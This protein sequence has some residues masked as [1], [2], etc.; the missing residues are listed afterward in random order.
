[1]IDFKRQLESLIMPLTVELFGDHGVAID[2]QETRK[3]FNADFTLV[4]FPFLKF[5]KASPEKTAEIV[6]SKISTELSEI[7]NFSVVKGFLNLNLSQEFVSKIFVGIESEKNFGITPPNN[8][9]PSVM[10]EYSSPNTNKPLHLGHIRNNLIGHSIS[11]ILK[12]SGRNVVQVQIIN[13]RGVHICKSM[14]AWKKFGNNETPE[15]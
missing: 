7:N 9:Q 8:T 12:A 15:K 13:D 3:E 5:S 1:M 4:V 2:L 6:G 14:W 11:N 10:V